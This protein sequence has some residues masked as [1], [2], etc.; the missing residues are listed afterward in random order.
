M[1]SL[2]LTNSQQARHKAAPGDAYPGKTPKDGRFSLGNNYIK[3][4]KVCFATNMKKSPSNKSKSMVNQTDSSQK[5]HGLQAIVNFNE[6]SLLSKHS[7]TLSAA[8]NTLDESE[9]H[10]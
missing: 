3:D 10:Y 1:K 8:E 4:A 7:S 5:K 2:M 9:E 6:V